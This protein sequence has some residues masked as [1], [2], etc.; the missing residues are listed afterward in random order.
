MIEKIKRELNDMKGKK[1]NVTIN[2]IRNKK[3]ELTGKIDQLYNQV[4]IVKGD[5]NLNRSFN[6]SDV[7]IG[8]VEINKK[9]M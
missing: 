9:N 3:D 7:L 6:Y 1:V 2:N 8:N 5:D 4:F